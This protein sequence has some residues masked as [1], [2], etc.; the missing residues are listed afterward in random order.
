[1]T[2]T[3]E[4]YMRYE[5]RLLASTGRLTFVSTGPAGTCPDC[6]PDGVDVDEFHERD[7]EPFFSW[8]PC[9]VCGSS[10]GGDREPVH[11]FDDRGRLVHLTACV[12]CVYYLEYGRLDDMSML[13]IEEGEDAA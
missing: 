8:R 7:H 13:E 5:R 6:N 2:W 4:K 1:M 9:E 12:D 3:A 10:L 11:G